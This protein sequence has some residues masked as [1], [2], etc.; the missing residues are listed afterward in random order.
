MD[1][2]NPTIEDS[3]KK[4]IAVDNENC[5]LDILDTAGQEDYVAMRDQYLRS[6]Q[7]FLF[8]FSVTSRP[9]FDELTPL[10]NQLLFVKDVEKVPM[11]IV[12]NKCDLSYQR[13][14]QIQEGQALATKMNCRYLETSAKLRLN[15]EEAFFEIVREIR[16]N[17]KSNPSK[18]KTKKS[19]IIL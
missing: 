13:Q 9:S 14:V 6:G 4:Y 16:K 18:K 15:V 11:A 5:L 1:E 2:Y 10:Y 7:G 19:C 3:Y 17:S 12:G 8:A